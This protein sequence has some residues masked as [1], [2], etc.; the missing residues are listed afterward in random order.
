MSL[1][2]NIHLKP[3]DLGLDER[4][5]SLDD[6]E[7]GT[8]FSLPVELAALLE[9]TGAPCFFM[10]E[11]RIS[12]SEPSP[13]TDRNGR[14][15]VLLLFGMT[16]GKDGIVNKYSSY[17]DRIGLDCLPVAE[18]GLGNLFVITPEKGEVMF[19]H[20]ECPDGE[21]SLNA[22]TVVAGDV[23]AFISS[24]EAVEEDVPPTRGNGVKRVFLDF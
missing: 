8:G 3:I 6:I 18:D 2:E 5:L 19:W 9:P 23:S 11:V 22:L 7:A 1:R 4:I 13:V 16:S 17:R 20:H 14:Q 10:E 24:L 21:S 12:V 15:L